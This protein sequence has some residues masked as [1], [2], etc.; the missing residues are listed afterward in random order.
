MGKCFIFSDVVRARL[1]FTSSVDI[2]RAQ[3]AV[4]SWGS[5][6]PF[7]YRFSV[8]AS[9]LFSF[10]VYELGQDPDRATAGLPKHGFA[11][12]RLSS[13]SKKVCEIR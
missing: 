8:S 10:A 5:V 13:I 3:S 6:R 12:S 4:A 7:S 9:L 11:F 1:C 2:V